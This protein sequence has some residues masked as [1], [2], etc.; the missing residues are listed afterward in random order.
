MGA[1]PPEAGRRNRQDHD[2]DYF[3]HS[4]PGAAVLYAERSGFVVKQTNETIASRPDMPHVWFYLVATPDKKRLAGSP[5]SVAHYWE[6]S[7]GR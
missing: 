1:Q 6:R 3:M 4:S 7:D 5:N 2:R